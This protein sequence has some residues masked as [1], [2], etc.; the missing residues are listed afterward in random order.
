LDS[1]VLY[2]ADAVSTERLVEAALKH[3]GTVYIRT[4]RMATP[5]IYGPGE[6]FP[7]GGCKVVRRSES[8]LATVI[9]AGVTLFE[10]LAAYEELQKEGI[11][12]RVID[13]Y[14]VKPVDAATL[15][16]AATAT[17][18]LITVEDHYPAGGINEA[19][20]AALAPHPVRLYS[21]AVTKK[22]KTGKPAE[23]LDYEDISRRAIVRLVKQIIQG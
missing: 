2:P 17:Q 12:I 23:L 13:L 11:N 16:T 5:I 10:A 14:S 4:S 7:L 21:L 6:E 20:L 9:A 22:P 18:G 3:R 8:D 19:V 15:L 1:V